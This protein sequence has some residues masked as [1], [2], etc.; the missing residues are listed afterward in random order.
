M[1]ELDLLYDFANNLRHCMKEQDLT[2]SDLARESHI[3]Q[4]TISAYLNARKMPTMKSI[5]NIC[6]ALECEFDD[7]LPFVTSPIE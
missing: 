1:N 2:Q 5:V 6:C 3:S 7:L 4:P